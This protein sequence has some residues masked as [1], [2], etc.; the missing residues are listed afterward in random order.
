[1][2]RVKYTDKMKNANIKS[3]TSSINTNPKQIILVKYKI[4]EKLSKIKKYAAYFSIVVHLH[5][6]NNRSNT[7]KNRNR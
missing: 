7:M 1:M 6:G 4:K 5:G 2:V 3:K